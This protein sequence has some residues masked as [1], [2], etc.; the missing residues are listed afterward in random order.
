[1]PINIIIGE[2]AI[3]IFLTILATE[4]RVRWSPFGITELKSACQDLTFY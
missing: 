3:I 1:M 2:Q 4:K